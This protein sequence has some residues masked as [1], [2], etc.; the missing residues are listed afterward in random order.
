MSN[1]LTPGPPIKITE[2]AE[3][4]DKTTADIEYDDFGLP[5]RKRRPRT[6]VDDSSDSDSDVFKSAPATASASRQDIALP[7][8]STAKVEQVTGKLNE[9]HT[10]N[11]PVNGLVHDKEKQEKQEKPEKPDHGVQVKDEKSS[12][13]TSPKEFP[14]TAP[15]AATTRNRSISIPT[16][17]EGHH[18]FAIS[19]YSHQQ[20]APQTHKE[21]EA[22]QEV[23]EWQEMPAYAHFDMYNDD[24][25]LVA[26][27]NQEEL[28]DMNGYGNLGG[29]AKGYTR[30]TM[31]DDVESVTSM[32]DNTAYLFKEKGTT[33][34]D[35]DEGARDP[36]AQMQTTKGLLTEGQRIAY[37]GLVRL[38]MVQMA[39]QPAGLDRT[40]GTKKLLDLCEAALKMW[41]QKM[42]VRLYTHMDIDSSEQIMIEQLAE[43]GVEPPDLVPAL[44]QNARV[45]NPVTEETDSPR[46]S[47]SSPRPN[48]HSEK[49][50]SS[51]AVNLYDA[52]ESPPPPPY[53]EHEG[54]E[55]PE[56]R[57][58]SQLPQ[59]KNL[60][61]D[62]RWTILCDLFL[63]L[64]ADSVYDSRSRQLLEH[65]GSYLS[66]D[67]L[68]I[69]KFE[70][71]VTDAL[72]MQE[73]ANK[74]NWNEDDHMENRRKRAY[75]KRLAFMGLAT[76]GGGLVIGLSAGLLAPVIGAGLAAG[77]TTIGVAGTGTFLA[78]AGGAAIITTTGVLSG[79]TIAVRAADRRTGAVKTFEYRPLHNNKRVN[80][81]VTISGWMIGKVD[82][83]RLPYSTVDPVMGDIYSVLWE[84]EMLRSMGDT[85]NILATEA[86]TQG[87]QQVLGSTILVAL[88]AALQ[89][90]IVLT[91]LSYLIDNPWTVSQARADM[92]GLILAD[93][94]IDRNLG[95]RPITLVGFSLGS[96]VIFA[97]LKELANRGAFGIVQNVYMFGTPVVAKKDEYIKARAIVPGRF[98]NGYATNDWILGYLFR[99]TSGGIMRV[100][101]LAPVEVPGIENHNV[102]ELVPG[103]M[104]YRAAM[105][106]LLRE[107]GWSVESDEFTEI[108]DPD[109]ENHDKRQR[110]L[111]NEIEEARKELEKK[112]EKKGFSFWRK[113]KVEKKEWEV[114]D[115]HSKAPVGKEGDAAP[116]GPVLFDI[117]AIRAEVA[118]LAVDSGETIEIKEIKSTLPPMKIDMGAISP[119]PY[120]TLRETKSYND[121][122][123]P[124]PSDLNASSS[125]LS[126][127]SNG[128]YSVN[129]HHSD[130]EL[131]KKRFEE[132]DEH[133]DGGMTMTFESS[134]KD[135]PSIPPSKSPVPSHEPPEM[136][137]WNAAAEQPPMKSA[138]TDS[139]AN[140][141]PG[142]NAWADEYDDEFGKEKEM[143]MTFE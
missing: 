129:S 56:V 116:E 123:G 82:D 19:E 130:H 32:D 55:L 100:A 94:L 14:E 58:P 76:V 59:T 101:G 97:C 29:A 139:N 38:A 22:H 90:P 57:T 118:A 95:T 33:L 113:K 31:D 48:S 138:L 80:L 137:T 77:F 36:L 112:P 124:D 121:S 63:V 126:T 103:H 141:T 65:V 15:P 115:E 127:R 67:W 73:E 84:P 142:Y 18:A 110:E 28:E 37:V 117:D 71:R 53:N 102:T 135:P 66:V 40:K 108:E 143:K 46:L 83:V 52:A 107:V 132:Y 105:P 72:E 35:E 2:K 20:L 34:L 75:K 41:S 17:V 74:E 93:S 44:M 86:L 10:V 16:N 68:E 61:I 11:S 45:K 43:H 92:A 104:A 42:M 134:F 98:V 136:P 109:P 89:L 140:F 69:C 99:A 30:V 51:S 120:S 87:L 23:E 131:P 54:E 64:I 5:I 122:L 49:S 26:R 24:N 78:G 111:I 133:E 6:P 125:N 9:P 27:E 96:R 91:K 4:R 79:G 8:E 88:M 85:I 81:I 12:E 21:Q 70:K 114:Y 119:N 1:E 47:V 62:L 13:P 106:K 25:K 50:M 128:N 60:D 3:P 7:E 39:K